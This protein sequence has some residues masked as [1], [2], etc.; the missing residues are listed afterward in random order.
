[1]LQR[2]SKRDRFPRLCLLQ[3]VWAALQDF[4]GD[5]KVHGSRPSPSS[6]EVPTFVAGAT[7]AVTLL[8]ASYPLSE[9][10]ALLTESTLSGNDE[11]VRYCRWYIVL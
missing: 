5:T 3:D 1:M 4:V 11:H 8:L 6:L 9:L 10:F 7:D 2:Q